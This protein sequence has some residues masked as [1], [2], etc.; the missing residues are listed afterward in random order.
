MATF[1]ERVAH[2][3][4]RCSL[5]SVSI[6]NFSCFPFGVEGRTLVLNASMPGRCSLFTSFFFLCFSLFVSL[7]TRLS[8]VSAV[9][10]FDGFVTSTS[11]QNNE[12]CALSVFHYCYFKE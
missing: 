2:S 4:N 8:V 11:C 12:L 9:G 5:C 6:C 3:V 1:W 7:F 10:M